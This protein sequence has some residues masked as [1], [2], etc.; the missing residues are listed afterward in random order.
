MDGGR[1]AD[2]PEAG[3]AD[4][5]CGEA[6]VAAARSRAAFIPAATAA[7]NP[8]ASIAASPAR[9]VPPFELTR[10]RNSAGSSPV[11]AAS[12]AAPRTVSMAIF[13]ARAGA[14]PIAMPVASSAS[15]NANA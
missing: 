5:A 7:E 4:P 15:M 13:R 12:S 2:D 10:R 6:P 11:C 9:V 8:P 14:I 3:R 1:L